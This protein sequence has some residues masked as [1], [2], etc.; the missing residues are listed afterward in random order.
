MECL[1]PPRLLTAILDHNPAVRHILHQQADFS[2]DDWQ[3][4]EAALADGRAE[5][6]VSHFLG[7]KSERV[8]LAALLMTA[9]YATAA[10]TCNPTFWHAWGGLD[11]TNRD[12][13]L[14]VL[15]RS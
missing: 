13:L 6:V 3:T 7:N 15:E 12:M 10:C 1:L 14:A 8:M 9:G 2:G 5:A 11:P 4:L